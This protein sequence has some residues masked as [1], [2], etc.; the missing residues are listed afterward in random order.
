MCVFLRHRVAG[1]V[2]APATARHF[3][4]AALGPLL[5]D[6]PESDLV[7]GDIELVITELV[8]NS[9]RAAAATVT[10]ELAV[11]RDHVRIVVADDAGGMPQIQ[12]PTASSDHGR[13]LRIIETIAREW[14]AAPLSP[15]KQVWAVVSVDA[16]QAAALISCAGQPLGPM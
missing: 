15:G 10:L 14:G 12:H 3:A 9:V 1:G 6:L 5:Q 11:H 16:S 7:I 4:T 13:G 2:V 8:T